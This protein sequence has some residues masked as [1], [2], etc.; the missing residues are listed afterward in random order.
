MVVGARQ[1]FQISFENIWF[2]E[3]NR[4]LFKFFVS[5]FVSDFETDLY[6]EM[7]CGWT[8]PPKADHKAMWGIWCKRK[9]HSDIDL[10]YEMKSTKVKK[11][12]IC[13]WGSMVKKIRVGR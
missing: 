9:E 8:F 6:S 4:G 3:N 13:V 12:N 2:L 1:N 11:N 10:K 5:D 7:K